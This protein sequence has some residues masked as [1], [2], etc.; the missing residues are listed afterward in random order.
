MQCREAFQEPA[1]DMSWLR[2]RC[3]LAVK[4]K[5]LILKLS[6]DLLIKRHFSAHAGN[7]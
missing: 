3:E 5:M 1:V 7:I 4:K 6:E 2:E